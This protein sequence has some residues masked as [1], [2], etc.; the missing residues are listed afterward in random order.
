MKEKIL[1]SLLTVLAFSALQAQTNSVPAMPRLVVG[2]TI[3]Q[4]RGDYLEAFAALYGNQGFK[5]LL[6]DGKIYN[7]VLYGFQHV[8]RASAQAAIYSGTSPFKNGIVAQQWLERSVLRPVFCVDD[9][10][11]IGYYTTECT[12]PQHLLVSL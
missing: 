4:F 6:A 5:R 10:N 8:D 2:I 9:N 3:D 7:N 1:S 11:F 12:S